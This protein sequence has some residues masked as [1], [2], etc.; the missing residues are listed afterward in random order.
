MSNSFN[1]LFNTNPRYST[2]LAFIIGLILIDDLNV[3][4]QNMLGDWLMLVAQTIIT[5]ANSQNIIE[6]RIKQNQININSKEVKCVY[7]P[8]IYDI[9]K[10]RDIIKTLYPNDNID[11]K[12]LSD[13]INEIKAKL[14]KIKID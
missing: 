6:S 14:D 13:Y 4:E 10:I 7:F 5:N 2:I 12:I 9:N 8:F 1:K 11:T 3:N